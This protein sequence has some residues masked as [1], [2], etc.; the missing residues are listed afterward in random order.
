MKIELKAL[1]VSKS[2]KNKNVLTKVDFSAANGSLYC[3]L[4]LNGQG[5][6]TFFKI[7]SGQLLP[8]NGQISVIQGNKI[9]SNQLELKEKTAFVP[10]IPF[11]N[12]NLTVLE[13]LTEECKMFC[14]D[15]IS[16]TIA[17][18]CS[19]FGIF[20]VLNSKAGTLSKG[21]K[22]RISLA[23]AYCR[24]PIVYILDEVTSGLD[25]NLQIQI[26]KSL[27]EISKESVVI[28]STHHTEEAQNY[29]NYVYICR[30]GK[31]VSS[32]VEEFKS[33]LSEDNLTP[34]ES[35]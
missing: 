18:S 33:Y 29:G 31:I 28:F 27:K 12:N 4:G 14:P 6:S 5:K 2:F 10:E 15:R 34:E 19:L 17:K 8:D 26:F 32:S 3:V 1:G 22:Q 23:K 20:D 30:R 7:L 13:I 24:Q 21:F 11:L 16:E 35:Q 9:Y 25:A